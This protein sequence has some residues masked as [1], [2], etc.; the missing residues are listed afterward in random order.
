MMLSLPN[1]WCDEQVSYTG[2]SAKEAKNQGAQHQVQLFANTLERTG[3]PLQFKM[4][5]SYKNQQFNPLFD[6]GA[7]HGFL[8]PEQNHDHMAFSGPMIIAQEYGIY[9]AKQLE[10][11]TITNLATGENY[12]ITRAK[13]D[14]YSLPGQLR[15]NYQFSNLDVS[16]SLNFVSHRTALVTTT[17]TNTDSRPLDL[18]LQWRGELLKKW[19][20]TELVTDKIP[21]WAPAF[22]KVP[23]GL[24]LNFTPVNLKWDMMLSDG[25][26]YQIT[27]SIDSSTSFDQKNTRYESNTSLTLAPKQTR[28]IYTSHSYFHDQ[29]E[30]TRYQ[31]EIVSLLS[32]PVQAI[33][34][35]RQRWQAY[36]TPITSKNKP[37]TEQ[38]LAVKALE[39]LI[40]NWRSPAGSIQ[41]SGITPSVT[42]RWFNGLWAWDSWKH[43]VAIAR[44]SPSLAKENLN[45][46][47]SYQIKSDDDIRPQ[48]SGM[49]IDAIFFNQDRQRGGVGGNWNERNTKPPLAS[50]AAW[51]IYQ[52][53]KDM[54]FI[55]AIFPKLLSY[56]QW[57]YRNRDHDQNG[58]VEYGA[59]LHPLHNNQQGAL[60]FTVK[61]TSKE[62]LKACQ[63]QQDSWYRCHGNALYQEIIESH[64]YQAIDIGAQHGAAW[65]SGMDNAARFGFINDE[66]LQ[67]YAAKNYQGDVK[68]AQRDWQVMFLENKDDTGQVIGFSLNQESVELNSYLALEKQQLAQM[69]Q[70]LGK[71]SLAQALKQQAADLTKRINQCFYD[72]D[73]G[74]YYDRQLPHPSAR[75]QPRN[76]APQS[77]QGTLLIK[78][79]KGPE[80]WAPL[81]AKIAPKAYANAVVTTM[82]SSDEFNSLVPFPT[83]A[84]SNPAYHPDIY[85][86]GRVWLDQFYF[87]I[88]AL[89]NYGFNNHADNALKKLYT[90]AHGLRENQSIRENYHPETG[91]VQGATNFSWSA[92]HLLM[93]YYLDS[94]D[95]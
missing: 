56:H 93:L 27:R 86:R 81:W 63:L 40:G 57:W 44:H 4:Y 88:V 3:T 33:N 74:F 90:N 94:I 53:T 21:Q 55:E 42:A 59:T 26:Q 15:L 76:G 8:L 92:A 73:S 70:V 60:S 58:L 85:W 67:A 83:A 18:S 51:Q 68:K 95:K 11:L 49:I 79:G 16:I 82:L 66:Q 48:D 2:T 30:A 69:A 20:N 23:Q 9:L 65:E 32:A 7:W 43:I 71:V 1:A 13:R 75:H 41:H 80:G 72:N 22:S 77:C 25:A 28:Q 84:I 35:S 64:D 14:H 62:R 54:T 46:M 17:L 47:F 19:S 29:K 37:M 91:A 45:T 31:E 78:R 39:T 24:K 38:R 50:W 34:T 52:Q 6:L 12:P 61:G 87:A 89:R 10:A 36:L 5:D